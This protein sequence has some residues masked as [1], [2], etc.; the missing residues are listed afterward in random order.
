MKNLKVIRD[1]I[2]GNISINDVE[3]CLVDTPEMQRLRHIKQN[4]LCYLVYPAMNSTRFEHSLGVMHLAGVVS[5]RLDLDEK[6]RQSLRV[7]GLLHDL[8]HCPFSHSLDKIMSKSGFSHEKI[9]SKI[10]LRTHVSDILQ[11]HGLKP[12]EISDLIL[13]R[14]LLSKIISS[15][16]DVDK[17]DYLKRDSYYAGVAYGEIDLERLIYAIKMVKKEI[18]IKENNLETI[19]SLL[20]NR[21]L[22]YQTV[23]RHHTKRIAESMFLHAVQRLVSDGGVSLGQLASMDD[24]QLMTLLRNSEGYPKEMLSRLDERKLFKTCFTDKIISFRKD[25]R[26][27]LV[28]EESGIETQIYSD[29]GIPEGYLFVDAPEPSFSE[30]KVRIEHNG[31]LQRIDKVS[32]LARALEKSEQEKLTVGVYTSPEYLKKLG[33]F[34]SGKYFRYLK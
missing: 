1:P 24:L 17:M 19:E 5:E 8:G 15:E 32:L 3:L 28:G 31:S 20:I 33:A 34:K 14:S 7:A 30:F 25:F 16:I 9:S 23:Y 2:H 10:I 26:E 29:Y 11:D 12:K 4:G 22:M 27:R 18:I 6:K 13:G 21:N